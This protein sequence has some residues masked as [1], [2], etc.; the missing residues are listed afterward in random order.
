MSSDLPSSKAAPLRVAIAGLG[1][2]GSEVAR[3]LTHR[4]AD[5]QAPAPRGFDI[6]AVSARSRDTDRGFGMDGIDWHDNAAEL[7]SRDDVDIIVEMIGGHEGVALDLVRTALTRGIHVVTANKALLA[8]HGTELARL[9][10]THGAALLFE[11]AIAGGIPAVKALREGLAGNRFSRVSGILNGTCNYILTRMERTGEA[12]DDVLADAQ[13]LGYAEAEP[14]LDVD[15]IDAAHKLTLLAAIAFGQTP[16][17]DKVSIAGIRDVSAVDFA[18]AAQLGYRI[19]LVGVAEP[20]RMPRMQTCLLPVGT[21]LA[22]VDGVLNA[23]A[24]DSEPVGSI[25]LTG[26]GAGA[27]PTSSAVLA[28]LIDIANNRITPTFGQPLDQLA[29]GGAL[30]N[31]GGPDTPFYVRL[32]VVDRPG[33]LADITSILQTHGMSVESL[34]QQ[35]R[36]PEDVVALVMTTHEVGGELL[37]KVLAEIEALSCV[38]AKPVSMP[39][40]NGDLEV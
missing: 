23:V 2:V 15:G 11:A 19:K 25:V 32:M 35:G 22:K 1:V 18:Y 12:F 10:E 7:A 20:G 37:A 39:I 5:L 33:V 24:Y 8:H 26:P 4:A 17:F 14:S 13:A 38:Q 9:A 30:E 21:Q 3:Q 29:D 16:D 36:A 40:L 34:L 27:G 28:D 31:G 6:V